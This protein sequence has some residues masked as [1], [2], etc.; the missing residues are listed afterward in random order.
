MQNS[1]IEKIIIVIQQSFL[2][3]QK[4]AEH[5]FDNQRRIFIYITVG[6]CII[7]SGVYLGSVEQKFEQK[8]HLWS[9][10]KEEMKISE[11]DIILALVK[12][13]GRILVNA[14][15]GFMLVLSIKVSIYNKDNGI[16][17]QIH[18]VKQLYVLELI[19]GHLLIHQSESKI[20]D[21]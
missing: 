2:L 4:K 10:K 11:G 12:I 8:Q 3:S 6:S 19:F 15:C 14:V 9:S 21:F 17:V 13:F 1:G 16:L 20:I 5:F 18:A 7:A